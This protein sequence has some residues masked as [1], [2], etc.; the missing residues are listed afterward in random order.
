MVRYVAAASAGLTA[1]CF[2]GV[3][4]DPRGSVV[5]RNEDDTAHRVTVTPT[6]G[7]EAASEQSAGL[8]ASES[9]EYADAFAGG[10]YGV[11]VDV[12]GER[13]GSDDLGVGECER[14]RLLVTVTG[15][16]ETEF[17]QSYC[18]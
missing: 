14:I 4:S 11:T 18:D 5:V 7:S 8:N 15:D 9:V 17:Q 2:G 6:G 16:G 3:W 13:A 10:S 1:G 12:D